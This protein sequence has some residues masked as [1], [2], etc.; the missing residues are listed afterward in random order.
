MEICLLDR[1]A[2]MVRITCYSPL[3][4]ALLDQLAQDMVSLKEKGAMGFIFDLSKTP[5]VSSGAINFL[6]LLGADAVMGND[7]LRVI[8]PNPKILLNFEISG[9]QRYVKIMPSLE[10]ATADLKQAL[11]IEDELLS[12]P[13]IVRSQDGEVALT[14]SLPKQSGAQPDELLPAIYHFEDLAKDLLSNPYLLP[15][16][17]ISED[18][19]LNAIKHLSFKMKDN[20]ERLQTVGALALNL[21]NE[22]LVAKRGYPVREWA[23]SFVI[24]QGEGKKIRHIL[25]TIGAY[26][27]K[28]AKSLSYSQAQALDAYEFDCYF[29]FSVAES[30]SLYGPP[31]GQREANQMKFQQ[32][33][34]RDPKVQSFVVSLFTSLQTHLQKAQTTE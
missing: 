19:I 24:S 3:N 1:E 17:E 20:Y 30:C 31:Q 10:E 28:K 14:T 21:D 9:L 23:R 18:G 6:S 22:S 13:Q 8:C 34:N 25:L 29:A 16:A 32:Y 27:H 2:L 5:F 4:G 33:N 15:P 7:R 12:P 26:V 11:F